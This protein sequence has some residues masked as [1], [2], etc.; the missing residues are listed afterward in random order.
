M[1]TAM[2]AAATDRY[3]AYPNKKGKHESHYFIKFH[4]YLLS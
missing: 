1:A 2:A 3:T 4:Y